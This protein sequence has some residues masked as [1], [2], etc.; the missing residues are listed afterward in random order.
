MACRSR[1]RT[2]STSPVC[3]PRRPV[4]PSATIRRM[5]PP[6]WR[7]CA[8]RA[9]SSSA[10]P[11]STSSP[12]ALSACARPMACR[13]IRFN[14]EL[15]PGGSSSGSAV[16]V[17]AGLVPLALGTDTAGSGRVPAGFNNIVGLKPS[18]GLISTHGVVPACRTLDCVSVF[19]LT[20]DDA[21]AAARRRWPAPIAPTAYSRNRPLG[22]PGRDA[23]RI[24][25]SACRCRASGCFSATRNTRPVTTPRSN[26]SASSA[27]KSSRSTSSRSTRPRGCCTK[28][29]G[30]PSAPSPRKSCWLPIRTPFI[31]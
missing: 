27:A 9:P 16:A 23:G 2:I 11:I 4:R 21:W 17:A 26:V 14:A 24:S 5:T 22:T 3:R 15:I 18:L 13:A 25:S 10:R 6:R 7:G 19:A 28:A 29:R 30:W 31:R 20:V 8:P 1:S 12:P